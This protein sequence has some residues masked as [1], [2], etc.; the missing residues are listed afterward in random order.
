VVAF[1]EEAPPAGETR[2]AGALETPED[3]VADGDALTASPVAMTVPT[4]S[5]P[6]VKPGSILTCPW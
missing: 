4:Y 1:V 3:P 5:W 2:A 6:M